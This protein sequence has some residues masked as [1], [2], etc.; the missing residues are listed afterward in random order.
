ME[1]DAVLLTLGQW[2]SPSYPLGSF[3]Y[4]HG[5]ETVIQR[6][7]I[8]T[9]AQLEVWLRDLLVHG[10]GQADAILLRAAHACRDR[11]AVTLIDAVA[12]A[13][14]P[15]AERLFES[16]AQGT[17]FA[18]TTRTIWKIDIP[19]LTHPVAAGYASG[20]LGIPADLTVLFYL[21]AFASNL[22]SCAVRLVPLGQTE[23][24]AV[25]HAL[26]AA[27]HAVAD[28]TRGVPPDA[29]FSS[30]FAAEIAAMHHETL[31]HR[32]FRT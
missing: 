20:Q 2:F 31:E 3:A 21:Q 24:Q 19:D 8:S 9:A 10:S 27:C 4:S 1:N 6:G 28:A 23:G 5:L 22:V 18:R 14:A 7:G 13:Y 17:A 25:L 15:S 29:L 30:C 16:T 26:G 12:R 11:D 32:I